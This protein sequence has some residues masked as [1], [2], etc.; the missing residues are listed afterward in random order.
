MPELRLT[1]LL[2]GLVFLGGLA[3]WELRRSRQVRGSDLQRPAPE[4]QEWAPS[5]MSRS[6][7]SARDLESPRMS[8]RDPEA[9]LPF[10]EFERADF[11]A[12]EARAED[13]VTPPETDGMDGLL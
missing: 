8:A 3:W 11:A 5:P 10:V 6:R 13:A 1:L 9:D 2:V 7:D 12:L 4:T